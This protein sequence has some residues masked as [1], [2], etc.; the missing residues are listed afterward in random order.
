VIT[1]NPQSFEHF[2]VFLTNGTTLRFYD[3]EGAVNDGE[4]E[5]SFS[6]KSASDGKLNFATLYLDQIVMIAGVP[7]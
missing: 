1:T 5:L 3:I 2:T 6:Y 7:R 4:G